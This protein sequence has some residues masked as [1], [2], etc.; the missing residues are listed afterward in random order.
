MY[1]PQT[2]K[3]TANPSNRR[4]IFV[5]MYGNKRSVFVETR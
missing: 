5:D 1:L 3:I 4:F 2:L